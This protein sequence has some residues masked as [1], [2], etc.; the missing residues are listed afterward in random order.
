MAWEINKHRRM[1]ES[2]M[3]EFEEKEKRA[4]EELQ[5]NAERFRTIDEQIRL[6]DECANMPT[7]NEQE[8]LLWLDKLEALGIQDV[9]NSIKVGKYRERFAT[10]RSPNIIGPQD[11][12][13]GR[14]NLNAQIM[15]V[16]NFLVRD[17]DAIGKLLPELEDVAHRRKVDRITLEYG[18]DSVK[19]S[20]ASVDL[21]NINIRVAIWVPVGIL[22]LTLIGSIFFEAFKPEIL[23]WIRQM[24]GLANLPR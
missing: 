20:K 7:N 5:R 4:Q 11:L 2:K 3:N 12:S 24:V 13:M 1:G 17:R 10:P 21:T 22:V 16:R 14:N 6:I 23:N 8:F 15:S 9:T 18:K 19:F